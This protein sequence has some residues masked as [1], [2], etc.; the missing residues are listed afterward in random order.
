MYNTYPSVG[1][2]LLFNIP[3]MESTAYMIGSQLKSLADLRNDKQL[4]L[5]PSARKGAAVLHVALDYERMT[6]NGMS[7]GH[8]IALMQQKSDQYDIDIVEKLKTFKCVLAEESVVRKMVTIDDMRVGMIL[9][10]DVYTVDHLLIAPKEQVISF[11]VLTRLRNFCR[12]LGVK[13]P[14]A[15]LIKGS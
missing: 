12:G 10:Q 15:V 4:A 2:K 5:H 11:H 14:I 8:A 7:Q 3:R 13:E 9:D 6:Y 1:E